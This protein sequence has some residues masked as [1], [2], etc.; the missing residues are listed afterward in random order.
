[1]DLSR[2]RQIEEEDTVKP[3]LLEERERG[4]RLTFE[5]RARPG[6]T[7]AIVT[8]LLLLTDT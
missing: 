2:D 4:S 1:M 8:M 7:R 5:T 6:L 3:G